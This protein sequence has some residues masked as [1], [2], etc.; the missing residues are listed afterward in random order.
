MQFQYMDV[1]Q[2][3]DTSPI[4]IAFIGSLCGQKNVEVF[5]HPSIQIL[6]DHHWKIWKNYNFWLAGF[7]MGLCIFFFTIWSNIL[8]VNHT[9]VDETFMLIWEILT[10]LLAFYFVGL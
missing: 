4:G 2:I 9:R 8:L 6:V 5:S 7:P 1:P 10:G 3:F